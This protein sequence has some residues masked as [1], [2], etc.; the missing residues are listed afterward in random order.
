MNQKQLTKIWNQVPQDYYEREIAKNLLKRHWHTLKVETFKKLTH[1]LSPKTILDNGC[2]SGRMANE[3]SQ[4]FPNAKIT[5]IDIYKKAISF[6]RKA[7]PHI[8]FKSGDA[9]KLPYK[10]NSFDLITSY[11]VIEHLVDP[12]KAL[13]EM[14]RVM[15]K[16]GY[17]I[18][19]MDSGNLLFR[20]VWFI[21]EKTI[22]KVWQGAHLHPFKHNDLEKEIRKAGFKIIK[23]HFSHY[24][25]EVSF[26]LRKT[27]IDL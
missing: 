9:H 11:E 20:I 14:K 27:K 23:K 2:A 10:N 5:G 4:I 18:V 1:N 24:S 12:Q 15:N 25:M 16:N 26:L 7:Y 22:S 3:I 17:T 13:R 21:S 8:K 19:A 6:G